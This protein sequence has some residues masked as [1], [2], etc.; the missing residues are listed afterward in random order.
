LRGFNQSLELGEFI[1]RRSGLP[2][3]QNVTRSRPT[4]TQSGLTAEERKQNLH[5]A[6]TVS[7]HLRSRKPLIIDD[8]MTTGE[9]CSQLATTLLSSGAERVYVLTI[10]RAQ[11]PD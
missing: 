9:T 5:D 11:H 6:F 4:K 10:A 1:S 3:V 8:V 7:G 2:L